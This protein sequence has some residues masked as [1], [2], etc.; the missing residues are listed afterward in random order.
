METNHNCPLFLTSLP[1][2]VP[3]C[4]VKKTYRARSQLLRLGLE[5]FPTSAVTAKRKVVTYRKQAS[6]MASFGAVRNDQEPLSNPYQTRD[7]CPVDFCPAR[8]DFTGDFV[9]AFAACLAQVM[10]SV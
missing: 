6:R 2:K 4:S 9:S 5:P 8:H 1:T 7:L 10:G 3:Q